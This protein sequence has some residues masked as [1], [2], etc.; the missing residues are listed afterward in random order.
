MIY[1]HNDYPDDL[2]LAGAERKTLVI[3]ADTNL[4][5]DVPAVFFQGDGVTLTEPYVR[6]VHAWL[7]L[8]L[9]DR[10]RPGALG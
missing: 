9:T 6:Q 1:E 5:G 10:S 7:T 4:K 3:G 8:W 2:L